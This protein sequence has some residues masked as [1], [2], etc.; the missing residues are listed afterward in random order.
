[1]SVEGDY[2]YVKK[3]TDLMSRDDVDVISGRN[4]LGLS[5]ILTQGFTRTV[6]WVDVGLSLVH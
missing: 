4:A 3:T 2:D 5:K 1:M 6:V